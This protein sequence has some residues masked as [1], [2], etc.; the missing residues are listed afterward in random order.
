MQLCKVRR[1]DG[2]AVVGVLDG[3]RVR[4]L[5]GPYTLSDVLHA[6]DPAGAAR[7]LLDGADAGVP[8]ESVTLLAP[9]DDQE[10]WAAGVTYKRS[11]EARERESAGAARFY[12]LVYNAERPELFFK[13][14]ARR[15]V[16]PGGPV[17][18]RRDSRWTVPEPEV[19]L[20]LSP[21]MK[22]VG[23][24]IG[25][26]VSARDIEGENPLYLPQAKFYDGAC[27]LGPAVTLAADLPPPE[28]RRRPPDHHA[29]RRRRLRRLDDAGGDEAL[30]RGPGVVAGPRDELPGR[31]GAA[32]RH[33]RRAARRIHAGAGRRDRHPD[34]R[35]WAAGERGTIVFSVQCSVFSVQWERMTRPTRRE[36]RRTLIGC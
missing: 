1:P 28:P 5:N 12:D 33:G 16:G 31:R 26:D 20:I 21:T 17:R 23:Y 18:V 3:G 35:D 6:D 25:D 10:V 11:R 34:R 30:V 27:A 7:S 19:A 32:D 14:P 24:T 8:V 4:R 15:V 29:R 36:K 13:A 9:I 22:I 2:E